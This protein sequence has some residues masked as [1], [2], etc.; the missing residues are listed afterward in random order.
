MAADIVY[1]TGTKNL[2]GTINCH[3]TI[4]RVPNDG[5]KEC[6]IIDGE[7]DIEQLHE[8][9]QLARAESPSNQYIRQHCDRNET[10]TASECVIKRGGIQH[11][12]L[13]TFGTL[14]VRSQFICELCGEIVISNQKG[15]G[16]D[17]QRFISICLDIGQEHLNIK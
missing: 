17:C 2:P 13:L 9:E 5:V 4:L 10:E 11:F 1:P 7:S 6:I 8:P 14:S 16:F 15:D 3:S 12:K